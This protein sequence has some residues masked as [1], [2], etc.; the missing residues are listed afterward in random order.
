MSTGWIA[1]GF[2]QTLARKQYECGNTSPR[3]FSHLSNKDWRCNYES[4]LRSWIQVGQSLLI[5]PPLNHNL[6]PFLLWNTTF[7]TVWERFNSGG[8]EWDIQ[9]DRLKRHHMFASKLWI[10]NPSHPS[11]AWQSLV[12]IFTV[13]FIHGSV[14]Q[15]WELTL[16]SLIS[17]ANWQATMPKSQKI[18]LQMLAGIFQYNLLSF[19]NQSSKSKIPPHIPKLHYYQEINEAIAHLWG[20]GIQGHSHL[21]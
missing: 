19:Q 4:W 8:E 7:P 1:L 10:R 9:E 14:F 15:I 18:K 11:W 12:L 3:L 20:G 2:H 6:Y 17:S 16:G 5:L 21:L 13:F